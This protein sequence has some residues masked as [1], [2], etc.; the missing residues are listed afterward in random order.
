MIDPKGLSA[1]VAI[2]SHASFE[3]PP[4]HC[5]LSNRQYRSV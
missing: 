1:F 3:K 5:A 2:I 4:H